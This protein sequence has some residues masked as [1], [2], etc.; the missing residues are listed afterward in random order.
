MTRLCAIAATVVALAASGVATTV[1]SPQQP[2]RAA[3]S[4]GGGAVRMNQIQFLGAHNAYHREM[5]G[6][7]LAE[8]IKI[9]PGY[10]SWGFYSHASIPDLLGRQNIRSVELDLLPDPK[11][12]LYRHPLAR[13]RAGLGPIDD[14]AMAA[15]G[16]KVLHVA[17]QDYNSTCRTLVSCMQQVRTWSRA[18]RQHVPIIFQLELKQTDDRW[19][20][21][22][23]AESPP[24]DPALLDDI[25]REIRSVFSETELITADDL[26][27][28]GLT[29]EQS[30]LTRG[31]PTLDSARGK[32]MFFFD[33]GGPG[34]IR[35]NDRKLER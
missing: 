9:D 6:V 5:Q 31:W 13:K 32:V 33:N 4:S 23:G 25:D 2:A 3:E 28:P 29:L 17:D 1:V 8:S 18:N 30:V 16:M 35:D 10:P 27:R 22:G 26:R 12:G 20:R 15:P 14:P 24:W 34:A 11:G 7:E 21:L 19:E